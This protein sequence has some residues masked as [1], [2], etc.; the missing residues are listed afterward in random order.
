MYL[1]HL[2]GP[3]H[4]VSWVCCESCGVLRC[5]AYLLW[6]ADLR[7]RPSWQTSTVQ[8]PRKT[9][10][11]TGARSLLT[12]WWR[13][14]VSGA[15]M[16]PCLPPVACLPLPLAAG[17]GPVCSWLALLWYLCNPL[18][19]ERASSCIRLEPFMGKFSLFFLLS[20]FLAIPQFG[21]LS[22]VA[23]SDYPQGI[24]ARSLP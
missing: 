4:S 13:M 11:A 2:P 9:W 7:L 16:A 22:H 6:E 14:P 3:G 23:P 24:Q 18:F 21:W 8:D 19:C 1:N 12:V 17:E 5:A 10:L 15:E 20:L